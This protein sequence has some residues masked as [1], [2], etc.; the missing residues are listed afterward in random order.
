MNHKNLCLSLLEAESGREVQKILK[1]ANLWDGQSNWEDF[2]GIENNWGVIGTQQSK[3]ESALVEKLVNSVDAVLMKECLI[4][5]IDPESKSAPRTISKAVEEFFK[6][7][8]GNL[9]NISA[10]Q[11]S[12]LATNIGLMATGIR[13]RPNYII[14]DRGEGKIRKISQIHSCH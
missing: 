14:F 1:D 5:G 12:S 2:G 4:R 10:N 3:P 11:R 6:V 7:K 9:S 8:N 13:S